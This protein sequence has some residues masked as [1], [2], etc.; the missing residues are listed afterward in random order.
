MGL[1]VKH[2]TIAAIE[3]APPYGVVLY[4]LDDEAI[5]LGEVQVDFALGLYRRCKESGEWPGYTTDVVE[6][7]LPKWADKAIE[8]D[9]E[10]VAA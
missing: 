10:E 6:I 2:Y 9:L 4:R 7:G 1:P 3:T 8:R 5:R